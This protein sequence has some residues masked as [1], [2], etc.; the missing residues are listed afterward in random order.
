MHQGEGHC[1]IPTLV[2]S[3]LGSAVPSMNT[4]TCALVVKAERRIAKPWF[5]KA[6]PT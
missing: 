5:P 4:S 3:E 1:V 2:S 6:D